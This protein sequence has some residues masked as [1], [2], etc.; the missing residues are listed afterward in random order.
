MKKVYV[1]STTWWVDGQRYSAILRIFDNREAA[2]GY[3]NYKKTHMSE[4]EKLD[5]TCYYLNTEEVLSKNPLEV[6]KL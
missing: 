2:D 4:E 3:M 1:V 5:D 6:K